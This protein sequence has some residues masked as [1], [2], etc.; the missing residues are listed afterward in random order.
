M[1]DYTWFEI[2]NC[3]CVLN[4]EGDGEF[5]IYDTEYFKLSK[6]V[7]TENFDFDLYDI[8]E[9]YITR[10]GIDVIATKTNVP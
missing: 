2:R 6:M 7:H 10:Y 5:E 9:I 3:V 4:A 8:Q 1:L